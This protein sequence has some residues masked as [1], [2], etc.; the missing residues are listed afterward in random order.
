VFLLFTALFFWK[1]TFS[2]EYSMLCSRSWAWQFY[3]WFQFSAYE[4]QYNHTFPLWDPFSY[5]GKNFLGEP[6]N[7]VF[8]PWNWFIFLAPLR[9]MISVDW[10]QF[11]ILLSFILGAWGTYRFARHAGLKLVGGVIAGVTFMFGGY[12]A[13]A[14]VWDIGVFQ[15]LL[16]LPFVFLV[17]SKALGQ[18][19]VRQQFKFSL[20]AGAFCGV[21]FLASVQA[22]VC[23]VLSL[24]LWTG[25]YI[26]RPNLAAGRK[27]AL[28]LLMIVALGAL[29]AASVQLVP[30][31][32]YSKAAFHAADPGKAGELPAAD[33]K[34]DPRSLFYL[35]FPLENGRGGAAIYF[36]IL[37]LFLSAYGFY[38]ARQTGITRF[39]FLALAA[40]LYCFSRFSVFHGLPA[41]AFPLLRV[42]RE[43]ESMLA[44]FHFGLA[45]L[46]GAGAE[47][48]AMEISRPDRRALRRLCR[49]SGML[50]G[51]VGAAL[52]VLSL[53]DVAGEGST[54]HI[55]AG[56]F[57]KL[58]YSWLMILAAFGIL[59]WRLVQRGVP[60]L[61]VAVVLIAL[62]IDLSGFNTPGILLRS[63]ADGV[64]NYY[65]RAIYRPQPLLQ[66]V[67][68]LKEEGRWDYP[69]SVFPPN[70]SLVHRVRATRGQGPTIPAY[71]M[72]FYSKGERALDLLNVRYQFTAA[73]GSAPAVTTRSSVVPRFQLTRNLQTLGNRAFGKW[74]DSAD[75][76][77]DAVVLDS[78]E[79]EKLPDEVIG[80]SRQK[81][82]AQGAVRLLWENNRRLELQIR[83]DV[84]AFLITSEQYDAGWYAYLDNVETP[85]VK[86]NEILRGIWLPAG[87]HRVSFCYLPV[88]FLKGLTLTTLYWLAV[89][90]ALYLFR[91]KNEE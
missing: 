24:A 49:W 44:T 52:L 34:V 88:G 72:D 9:W 57:A 12:M 63:G 68:S 60:R 15:G 33:Y 67:W 36:G 38:R 58:Y 18:I 1:I 27:T 55:F 83:N 78:Y 4:I 87:D 85:V 77:P 40:L 70:F 79:R 3:P 26:V 48:L 84:P 82:P 32:Q 90:A 66:F 61:F 10:V 46:A 73:A 47:K 81:T 91:I 75:Y 65:P 39:A 50:A 74:L 21:G 76:Q 20:L 30:A 86:C 89:F 53:F 41:S 56:Y 62:L 45:L 25:L 7:G 23:I 5:A 11:W 42:T 64:T 28:V 31:Q 37:P 16:W 51:V 69:D 80:L 54:A 17:F 14:A 29:A 35:L 71:Y 19:S 6:G 59:V 2:G 13:R 22:G 43:S 8:Y